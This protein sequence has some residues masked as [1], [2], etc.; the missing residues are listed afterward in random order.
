METPMFQVESLF[1]AVKSH[2][3]YQIDVLGF[4]LASPFVAAFLTF[5]KFIVWVPGLHQG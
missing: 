2:L 4:D 1:A 3:W 5:P